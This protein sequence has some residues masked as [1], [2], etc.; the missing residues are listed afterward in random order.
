MRRTMQSGTIWI[1]VG[2]S[3]WATLLLTLGACT[4]R[5]EVAA[6][7]KPITINLNVKIDHEIRMK[8]DKDLEQVLSNDSGLF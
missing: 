2:V 7:E 3:V 4:P 8:V 1:G 5:V 6:S